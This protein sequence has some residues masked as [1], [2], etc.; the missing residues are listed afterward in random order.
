MDSTA[1]EVPELKS[2]VVIKTYVIGNT[3][4]KLEKKQIPVERASLHPRMEVLRETV[5][6]RGAVKF[7]REDRDQFRRE[8]RKSDRNYRASV[9]N[10]SNSLGECQGFCEENRVLPRCG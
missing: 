9:R 10:E 1:E 6:Q 8:P 5:L 4:R 3:A 7:R 2:N